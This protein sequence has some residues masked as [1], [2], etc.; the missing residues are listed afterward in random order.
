MII[1]CP[2]CQ[3]RYQVTYEA[4]GS[5]GRQ[6]QCAHC[7][8][9]WQQQPLDADDQLPEPVFDA[10]AEDGLDEALIDEER[11]VADELER[12][13]EEKRLEDRQRQAAAIVDPALLRN[14]QKAFSRRRSAMEAELPLARLRRSMRVA[15]AL[16]L[17]G[18]LV[19][20]YIGRVQVVERF[21]EMAGVYAALGLGVNVVGLD[22]SNVSS[23]R[24]QRDGRE[25]LVV[26]AQIV[27]L[28]REPVPVPP[29]VVT[30][31]D[32]QG[33]GI[34]EWSVVPSVR[35]LMGGERSSF[36]TQLTQPPRAAN[37]VRLSFAGE[38]KRARIQNG[39]ETGISSSSPAAPAASSDSSLE[40]P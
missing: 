40:H 13:L 10:L 34:Y 11:R 39:P 19:T 1:T 30:L 15:G 17:V 6:V 31:L 32:A 36:D 16:L 27:G 2:H 3:T 35:D 14:R 37:S 21:P 20:A 12:R 25:V 22:F 24:T 9:A 8:R 26:S 38:R 4:I 29:V 5:A 23:M 28:Q 7:R 33:N 18:V